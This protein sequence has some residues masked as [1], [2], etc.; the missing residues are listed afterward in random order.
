MFPPPPSNDEL[1][2]VHI[3]SLAAALDKLNIKIPI[4]DLLKVIHDEE[5]A[6]RV[7]LTAEFARLTEAAAGLRISTV[8]PK[9]TKPTKPANVDPLTKERR[10]RLLELTQQAFPDGKV[11]IRSYY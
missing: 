1:Q 5:E 10:R 4:E 6:R 9:P 8:V 7:K 2:V 3:A 11:Q